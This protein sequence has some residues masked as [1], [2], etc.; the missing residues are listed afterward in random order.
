MAEGIKNSVT[1]EPVNE[2]TN[3]KSNHHNVV[4]HF[5]EASIAVRQQSAVPMPTSERLA[6]ASRELPFGQ[7]THE[8]GEEMPHLDE[9]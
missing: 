9:D 7:Q 1:T 8:I 4:D 6:E 2:L 3:A 5:T